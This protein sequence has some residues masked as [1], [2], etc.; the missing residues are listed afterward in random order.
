[1]SAQASTG[2]AISLAPRNSGFVGQPRGL[3]LLFFVE[4]WERFS[5]YGMKALL[6]LYLVDARNWPISRAANLY[7][8]YTAFAYIAPLL[9]GYL[10]DRFLGARRSLVWGG[11]IIALGH[12]TL[13]FENTRTFYLGLALVILGTGLFKPN[14]STMVGQLY[15]HEDKRRDTGFTIF[16]M[17]ISVGAFLAP[18]ACG[19]LG[20]KVGWHYGFGAAGVG[21]VLGLLLYLWGRKRYLA[22]IGDRSRIAPAG[23]ENPEEKSLPVTPDER[24]RIAA[25]LLVVLLTIPFW[26]CYEQFGSSLSLFA[27]RHIARTLGQFEIPASWF[28][29]INPIVILAFAPLVAFLWQWREKR[30]REPSAP[31]KMVVGYL[32]LAAGFG[33]ATLAGFRSETWLLVSPLWFVATDLF[34]SWGELLVSP[35]GLSYVTKVAPARY[36]SRLMAA[37]F[38]AEGLGNKVAGSIAAYSGVIRAG[39]FYSIFV[40]LAL[41]S[42]LALVAILPLLKR[43]GGNLMD[44]QAVRSFAAD[45]F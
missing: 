36:G 24:R 6:I 21:M 10:A 26:A 44:K 28:Q 19:Y 31:S 25:V 43:L 9:G 14:V 18:L 8:N 17:G 32:L 27:D 5:Y 7:G 23:K 38:L 20:Q 4:M 3:M 12:F 15:A 22:G 45:G 2:A 29:S 33:F 1:M 13:A 42:T 40:G 34:R 39:H 37:W 41:V 30:N 11:I 35:V 16:F